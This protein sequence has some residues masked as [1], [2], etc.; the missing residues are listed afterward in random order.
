MP[1]NE[2]KHYG[3]LGMKWGV[4]RN[5]SKAMEKASKKLNKLN[6]KANK[7][8]EKSVKARYGFLGS[9]SKYKKSK[10]KAERTMYKGKKWYESMEREFSKTSAVSISNKDRQIGKDFVKFFEQNNYADFAN[11]TYNRKF[12]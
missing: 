9:E 12:N 10:A 3:V 2:L 7:Q 6:A 4:R 11:S 5:P 8:L 1:E